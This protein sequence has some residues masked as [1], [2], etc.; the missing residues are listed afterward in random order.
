LAWCVFSFLFF[1]CCTIVVLC[2]CLVADVVFSAT[3][4]RRGVR[5]RVGAVRRWSRVCRC[6][7]CVFCGCLSVHG[8]AACVGGSSGGSSSAVPFGASSS[9]GVL[10]G[11]GSRPLSGRSSLSRLFSLGLSGSCLSLCIL[12]RRPRGAHPY[13]RGRIPNARLSFL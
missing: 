13:P 6:V 10:F 1:L 11:V 5:A 9:H 2:V 12:A 8:V 3:R 7:A 4:S